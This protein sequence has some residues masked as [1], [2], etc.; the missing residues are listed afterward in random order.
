MNKLKLLKD[1]FLKTN[2]YSICFKCLTV[3]LIVM[4]SQSY[5]QVV[6]TGDWSSVR[7]YGHAYNQ[8]GFSQ[9]EYSWIAN[10][11]FLFTIEKRHARNIYGNPTSEFASNLAAQQINTN[12]SVCK[13]LFY[14]NSSKIF[15]DIYATVQDA[16]TSN[17]S[18]VRPDD[19]WD[20]TNSNFRNWWVS[21]AEDQ[22]NNA[23]HEGV[24]VDAVPNVVGIQ[25]A[26]A[27][28]EL[29]N[30][31]DQLPGLVIYNGFYTPVNGGS[32][33]AGLSTLNHADGVF[34]EKFMNSTCD[35]KEKGKVLLDE[36]LLVPGEKYIIANSEHEPAWNSTD[37]KFSLACY[38][39]IAN[40]RSFYRYVDQEGIDYSSNALTYWHE[41]FGKNIGAP[42]GKATVNGYVY[43][44]TF[45]NASVTVDLENKTSSII[46]GSTT[47]LALSGTASQSSTGAGGVASRAI[48]GNT[49]GYWANG[50]VSF[51]NASSNKAWWE[52][53]LG[54]EYSI[55]DINIYGRMDSVHQAS[56]S[57]FTVLIY[58][59]SNTRIFYQ[60]FTSYPNPSVT[61]NLGG[62]NVKRVRI[63]QNDTTK[64]LALAE[65]QVFKNIV[66]SSMKK[67]PKS[68]L[69]T[70]Q[71]VFI[72]EISNVGDLECNIY[73][74]PV[75]N[76]LLIGTR[77]HLET[78]YEVINFKGQTVLSGHLIG[79]TTPVDFS[80]LFS[81]NYIVKVSNISGVY[82]QKIIK[83]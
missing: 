1:Y 79:K 22:V 19:R 61:L 43:T 8:D 46:W 42:L 26:T 83:K 72:N 59:A 34:V 39:I 4:S 3:L 69:D 56:L 73:P 63:R 33:L 66:N 24:F 13:P 5:A 47:N 50:S 31:M 57:N 55:G 12:N 29:E 44:R 58:D 15:D 11:N 18:W 52:V 51:A 21:I 41:D 65:V 37:H 62:M 16:V 54:A 32:L 23:W 9:A 74:N 82:T 64:P 30:M 49:D 71:G 75:E 28:S 60:T 77:D 17:P 40:N 14:W 70:S 81:G 67:D 27:L 36:L 10:H 80:S 78:T 35:T 7:L 2:F 45:E 68:V 53:D 20:Y 76:E 48:D 6:G 25:G 38:L